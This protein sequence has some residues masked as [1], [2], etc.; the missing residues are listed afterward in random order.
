MQG[1]CSDRSRKKD[2]QEIAGLFFDQENPLDRSQRRWCFLWI[3]L[4][5][6]NLDRQ[7]KSRSSE[8]QAEL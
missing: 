7:G 5:R 8:L 6:K 2:I 1:W 4:R 3:E